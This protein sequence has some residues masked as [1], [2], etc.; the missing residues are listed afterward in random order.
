MRLTGQLHIG[1]VWQDGEG[2]H[3]YSR[4]P[5]SDERL[6][7]GNTA[8]SRDVAGALCA[9]RD[10]WRTWSRMPLA[11][12]RAI[13]L[14]YRDLAVER[15]PLLAELIAR[16]SGKPRWEAEAEAAALAAKVD[17]SLRAYEE[18]TGFGETTTAF[19]RT[20]LRHRPHGVLV[21]MGPYNFPAH[22]PNGHIVPALI[23]GNTVVFK[24]SELTPAVGEAMVALWE[25]AGLVP[26]ALNLVQGGAS[27]G[28][29][30]LDPDR[31]DGLLFT[32][33]AQTGTLIHRAFAGRTDVI[34]ALEMG[35]NNP[36]VVWGATGVDDTAKLVVQ[37]AFITT[38]QRCS[39]ARRLIVS[40]GPAGDRVVSSVAARARAV[41]IGAWNEAPAPFMGPLISGDAARR[42]LDA[43]ARLVAAGA[44]PVLT[45]RHLDGRTGA[46]L[47]PGLLELDT[48]QAPDE[49][50]FGPLLM[51][52]RARN[53]EHALELA[54]DTRFGLA[55][56]LVA[57]QPELWERFVDEIH[58]GVVNWNRP[59]TGAASTLPFGGPGVSGNHRP[60]A[61][62]AADYCAYPVA[63]QEAGMVAVPQVPGLDDEQDGT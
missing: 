10:A 38:G 44:R 51:I 24:P 42:V 5:A 46:F 56:G 62:Y 25:E 14:R 37:S 30:L 60:G 49:E 33:S 9:A 12:R 27:V 36:L 59:T 3:L 21:V 29:S 47:S 6:W 20:A 22:L 8:S 7:V 31:I 28:Q 18:R 41:R 50:I 13:V 11:A 52:R 43:Q 53:F 45:S 55:A 2:E 17:V 61:W 58:A 54:N 34:L 40:E 23:A 32:G 39:C 63:S 4:D 15:K 35:G 16:E 57:D 48:I 26:G 1:G 19:G